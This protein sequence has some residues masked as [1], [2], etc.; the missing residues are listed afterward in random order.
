M[1]GAFRLDRAKRIIQ[2]V[3]DAHGND[4]ARYDIFLLVCELQLRQRAERGDRE[5]EARVDALALAGGHIVL[6]EA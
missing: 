6:F 1:A 3:F 5:V 2:A 4:T